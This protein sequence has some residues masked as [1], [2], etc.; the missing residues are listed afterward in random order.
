MPLSDDEMMMPSDIQTV[1]KTKLVGVLPEEDAV[2]LSCGY[3][4]PRNSDS[5]KAY[6]ML[7]QNVYK[8]TDK[9]FNVTD[10]YSGFFGSIRRSIKRNV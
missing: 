7:A 8:G 3:E 1:L 5:F 4:L 2:F 10:K 6:K 9:I